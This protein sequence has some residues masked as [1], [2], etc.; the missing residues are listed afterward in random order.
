MKINVRWADL[1]SCLQYWEE[2]KTRGCLIRIQ[3]IKDQFSKR[4]YF[5]I[6]LLFSNEGHLRTF[7]EKHK[8]VIL[9][10]KWGGGK[11]E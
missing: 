4:G 2:A 5:E 9:L 1:N 10:N 11:I 3:D 8:G 7:I 6:E